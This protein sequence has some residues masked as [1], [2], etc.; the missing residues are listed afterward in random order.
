MTEKILEQL[1]NKFL[2]LVN[3]KIFLKVNRRKKNLT[4]K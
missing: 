2:C 1:D 3:Q 4:G